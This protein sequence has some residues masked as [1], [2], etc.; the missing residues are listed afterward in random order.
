M[1]QAAQLLKGPKKNITAIAYSVGYY[2]TSVFSSTFKT[3]F[4]ISAKEYQDRAGDE[5]AAK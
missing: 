5:E 2:N 3:Y 1:N 4:G